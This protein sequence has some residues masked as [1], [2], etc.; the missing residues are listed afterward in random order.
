MVA[1]GDDCRTAVQPWTRQLSG[2]HPGRSA[3]GCAWKICGPSARGMIRAAR[4][5]RQCRHSGWQRIGTFN[6]RSAGW[7]PNTSKQWRMQIDAHAIP[8]L[9]TMRIDAITS[10]DVLAVLKPIWNTKRATAQMVRRRIADVM[11][12]AVAENWRTDNPAGDA[13]RD[14][15]TTNRA[16]PVQ[17]RR[18]LHYSDL[19]DA[20]ATLEATKPTKL[21][22]WFI[23]HT[24]C[25]PS[26]ARLATW[27]QIDHEN[28]VWTIP[29]TNKKE[30]KNAPGAA[31]GSSVVSPDR[32]SQADGWHRTNL[33]IGVWARR[34]GHF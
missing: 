26:E 4:R 33:S 30:K 3:G 11:K 1:A 9:G 24:V 6:V 7:R 32:S 12:F 34:F 20:L 23:H 2:S 5:S 8:V 10:A 17:H 31:D 21:L 27:E 22:A 13:I 16:E 19:P 28:R 25:R 14:A 18:K 29:H 15:L